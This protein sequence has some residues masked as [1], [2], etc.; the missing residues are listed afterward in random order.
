MADAAQIAGGSL[1]VPQLR[2]LWQQLVMSCGQPVD[3]VEWSADQA[4]LYG[5]GL[6]LHET[7]AFLYSERP[8]FVAFERWVLD[9]K[10]GA[11]AATQIALVNAAVSR[12]RGETGAVPDHGLAPDFEPVLGERELHC[13]DENGYVVLRRAAPPDACRDAARAIWEFMG[14]DPDIPETWRDVGRSEGIFVPLVQHP[15]FERN[16]RS[17]RIAAAFAQLWGTDDL[18][19]TT[20]RGGFNPPEQNG[21]RLTVPDLHWDTSLV[22]PLPRYFQG[23]LYLTDTPAEQGAFRCVPG[24]HRRLESW[25]AALPP[26]ADPRAQDL[27]AEAV[28]IAGEAG[29]MVIWNG[30]LPHGASPNRGTRPR[31]VQYIA[32]HP[33]DTADDR[34]WR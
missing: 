29:D 22:L 27:S 8:S 12:A 20:D 28:P 2:R 18:L 10:G 17:P 25:L 15:A 4:A 33:P 6:G 3:P 34:S 1:G 11:I 26:G 32:Y 9:C 7:L 13:W 23:I 24:F 30:A 14:I 5:L 19:V 16:R 31:L 21:W